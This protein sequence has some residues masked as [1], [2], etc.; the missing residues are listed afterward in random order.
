MRCILH[1]CQMLNTTSD[2]ASGSRPR[3]SRSWAGSAR[4]ATSLIPAPC[5]WTIGTAAASGPTEP[6]TTCSSW[7]IWPGAGFRQTTTSSCAPTATGSSATSVA[8]TA[9][10][11]TQHP[12]PFS[13]HVEQC[14]DSA[15]ARAGAA[16]PYIVSWPLVGAR[17]A[18]DAWPVEPTTLCP[19]SWGRRKRGQ[20]RPRGPRPAWGANPGPVVRTGSRRPCKAEIAGSSPAGSTPDQRRRG[21]GTVPAPGP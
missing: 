20:H 15:I 21:A 9:I 4:A 8:S 17:R 10:R 12:S 19:T 3:C 13:F 2:T 11:G 16:R 6:D 18:G 5:R 7:W 14:R 1:P